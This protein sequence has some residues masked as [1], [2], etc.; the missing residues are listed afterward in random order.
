MPKYRI[1][2]AHELAT[3][4]DGQIY[5]WGEV[6]IETELALK[7]DEQFKEVARTIGLNGG[8]TAVGIVKVTELDEDHEL[9]IVSGNDDRF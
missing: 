6:E 3:P 9:K 1:N 2:Y 8:H 7:T 5:G 4:V